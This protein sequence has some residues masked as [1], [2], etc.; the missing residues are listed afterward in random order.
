V[1]L[2]AL[3]W[4]GKPP[5]LSISDKSWSQI[6]Y[7]TGFVIINQLESSKKEVVKMTIEKKCRSCSSECA[8]EER[9]GNPEMLLE[10]SAEEKL[11]TL[12]KEAPFNA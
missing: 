1:N 3:F 10:E 8:H 4:E 12:S 6:I 7:S 11:L 2:R 9:E 5:I